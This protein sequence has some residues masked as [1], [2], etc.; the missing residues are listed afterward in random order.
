MLRGL[1][2]SFCG[3]K[4]LGGQ[5]DARYL[6]GEP[7]RLRFTSARQCQ[8]FCNEAEKRF[9]KEIKIRRLRRKR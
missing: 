2:N 7:L 1:F 3:F 9:G 8:L 6:S 5:T 4:G